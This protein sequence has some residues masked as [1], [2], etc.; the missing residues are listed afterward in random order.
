MS[1]GM[2]WQG[3]QSLAHTPTP[4]TTACTP[5][6]RDLP[7]S[8]RRILSSVGS[9]PIAVC[10]SSSR[11]GRYCFP[12]AQVV[13]LPNLTQLGEEMPFSGH[14]HFLQSGI[15]YVFLCVLWSSASSLPHRLF[16][17][18]FPCCEPCSLLVFWGCCLPHVSL[19]VV[20]K[21]VWATVDLQAVS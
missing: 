7:F 13:V 12:H 16:G 20:L 15:G 9:F 2:G 11:R 6:S 19:T 1:L 10:S 14:S 8:P 3:C 17:V 18:V 4:P 21:F 5:L